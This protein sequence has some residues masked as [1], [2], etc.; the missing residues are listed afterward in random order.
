MG[1]DRLSVLIFFL[2]ALLIVAPLIVGIY[3]LTRPAIDREDW[4]AALKPRFY[5]SRTSFDWI[6]RTIGASLLLISVLAIYATT[7]VSNFQTP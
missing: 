4:R 7:Q 2:L 3:F 1:S 5:I 6:V